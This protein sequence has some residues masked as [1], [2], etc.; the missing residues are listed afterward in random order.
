MPFL[1]LDIDA[2]KRVPFA[3]KSAGI[4]EAQFGWGLMTLWEWC[5]TNKSDHIDPWLLDIIFEAE[6]GRAGDALARFGF[7]EKATDGRFRVKGADRYL[8][9]TEARSEG[10][11]KTNEKRW[12]K[13]PGS[14]KGATEERSLTHR[15]PV[16]QP[17]LKSDTER[18]LPVALTPRHRDSETPI[19]RDSETPKGAAEPEAADG[20]DLR[21]RLTAVF[22]EEIGHPYAWRTG[23][24]IACRTLVTLPGFSAPEAARRLAIGLKA[25]FKRTTTVADLVREWNTHAASAPAKDAK[26][27]RIDLEAQT[28]TPAGTVSHDF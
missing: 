19:H 16:A 25:R 20:L 26:P 15:S 28:Y 1:Q 14:D 8:R 17:S 4:P 3:A 10:A 22:L 13:R 11:R 27:K 6:A 7:A 5:W 21:D 23:D 12:G 2:K 24:D 9:I 18:S